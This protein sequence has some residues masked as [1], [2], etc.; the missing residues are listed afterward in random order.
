MCH[1]YHQRVLD[2]FS[3][4]S[5]GGVDNHIPQVKIGLNFR[6][7]RAEF[8]SILRLDG[9]SKSGFLKGAIWKRV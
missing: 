5:N 6:M 9:S 8:G 7:D 2:F 4:S 3:E 1:L